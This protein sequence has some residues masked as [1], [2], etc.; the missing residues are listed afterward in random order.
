MLAR[1]ATALREHV[2]AQDAVI[3]AQ[4]AE[5][6]RLNARLTS[7]GGAARVPPGA[8]KASGLYVAAVADAAAAKSAAD[9]R[10]AEVRGWGRC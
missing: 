1:E 10:A 3:A 6:A 5:L 7:E 9:A 4:R 2:A 8:V